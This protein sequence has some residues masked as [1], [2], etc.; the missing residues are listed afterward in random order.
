M[1]SL[2][3]VRQQIKSAAPR[4]ILNPGSWRFDGDLAAITADVQSMEAEALADDGNSWGGEVLP[5]ALSPEQEAAADLKAQY[6]HL[7]GRIEAALALVEAGQT[8]FPKYQTAN[9]HTN[10]GRSNRDCQCPD[11]EYRGFRTEFGI[12]CKHTLA[13]EIVDRARRITNRLVI[14]ELTEQQDARRRLLPADVL[15]PTQPAAAIV[16]AA[17]IKVAVNAGLYEAAKQADPLNL[18]RDNRAEFGRRNY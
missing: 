13:Q 16:A 2:T 1:L 9:V 8:S 10:G 14:N 6:P 12:A 15:A 5:P 3:D 17:S 18:R 7:V 11:A 4:M